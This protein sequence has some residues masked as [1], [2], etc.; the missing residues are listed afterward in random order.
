MIAEKLPSERMR[1]KLLIEMEKVV[2]YVKALLR[3][4]RRSEPLSP[5]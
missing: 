5:V 1:R 3:K 2:E 4:P